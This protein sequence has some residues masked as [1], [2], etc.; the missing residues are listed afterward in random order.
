MALFYSIYWQ[1]HG[2]QRGNIQTTEKDH[3]YDTFYL[4]ASIIF[5]QSVDKNCS[6]LCGTGRFLVLVDKAY[7]YVYQNLSKLVMNNMLMLLTI[8]FLMIER[9][10]MDFAMRQMIFASV[11]CVA[12]LFIP[13]MIERF[14]YFDR[15]GWWYA[16]IG[17]AMLA[18][19][20]V[21]GVER[22]GAKNWI[23]I[24]GFAMQPSEFV[25]I[26]FVFL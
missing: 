12:G 23:Q 26:I 1:K 13:W 10:N 21:I 5:E 7:S 25:K 8:G 24:G 9:L 20:F 18:L 2:A 17:L 6:F 3:V 14:S 11:I 15:F 16:G 19:V 4:F 22:Y